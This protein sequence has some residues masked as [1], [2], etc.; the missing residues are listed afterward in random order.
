M[1]APRDKRFSPLVGIKLVET[2]TEDE[3]DDTELELFQSPC[4]D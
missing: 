2:E 3:D 1:A 4:G